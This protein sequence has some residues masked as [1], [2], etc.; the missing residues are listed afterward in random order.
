MSGLPFFSQVLT[1]QRAAGSANNTFTTA[2][3]VINPSE[4][5]TLPANYLTLGS[6][7]RIT[8][9]MA[10]SNV[11]TAQPTFTFQVMMGSAVAFTTGAITTNATANTGLPV[12]LVIDLRVDSI[13][14]GTSAKFMGSA[15]LIGAPFASGSTAISVPITTPAVGSG[16]DSTIANIL[17]FYVACQTNNAGNG[18][19]VQ[20][21]IVEQLN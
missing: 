8:V 6:R 15:T 4:L 11:V 18:V 7:L 3:S 17:D 13:G 20:D 2:R 1:S 14:S 12:R 19:T 10:L 9:L 21:Y 16:W 5:V